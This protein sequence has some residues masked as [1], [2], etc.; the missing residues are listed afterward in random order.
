MKSLAEYINESLDALC[1]STEDKNRLL[2]LDREYGDIVDTFRHDRNDK[3]VLNM[4][5]EF[6][7][8]IAARKRGM[9]YFPHI[10]LQPHKFATDGLLGRV[11]RLIAE[12]QRFNCFLSKY[13]LELLEPMAYKIKHV[14]EPEKYYNWYVTYQAQKPTY[15]NYIAAKKMLAEN[16]Y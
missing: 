14:L 8:F 3:D 10:Q 11:E 1:L 12:F 16:P 2:E 9:K 15:E 7:K 13:Y 4:D 5:E 6:S